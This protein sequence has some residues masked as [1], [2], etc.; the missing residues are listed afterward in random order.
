M[1]QT[2]TFHTLEGMYELT[3]RLEPGVPQPGNSKVLGRY[4]VV[5]TQD[6]FQE[7]SHF[8]LEA[9]ARSAFVYE[10]ARLITQQNIY[11]KKNPYLEE[12]LNNKDLQEWDDV[13]F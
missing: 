11:F 4:S 2:R 7:I 9:E 6:G 13:I 5:R 10:S 8:L 3:L 1:D 12:L